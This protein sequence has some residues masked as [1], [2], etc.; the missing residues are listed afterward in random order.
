MDFWEGS[1]KVAKVIKEHRLVT[2]IGAIVLMLYCWQKIEAND[3]MMA[4]ALQEQ[5]L[6]RMRIVIASLENANNRF[7]AFMGSIFA[8]Y[9]ATGNK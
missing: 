5:N 2:R 4:E 1:E 6:E 8:L 3:L 7:W 9:A